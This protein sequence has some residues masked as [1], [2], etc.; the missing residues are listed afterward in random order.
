MPIELTLEQIEAIVEEFG[1]CALRAK[2]CGFDGVEIHGAHG[3]LIAEF[4]SLYS[5]KRTD[6]YGGS[7]MNRLRFPVEIIKNIRQK[8][9]DDFIIDFR[10]SA[11]EM[12]EGGRTIE[13]TKAI[14]PVLQEAGIGFL[15]HVSAGTY[16]TADAIVHPYTPHPPPPTAGL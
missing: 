5:N 13:D 4:M 6:R 15:N 3:Y 14:V 2:K 11:D 9:G 8:C 12:V 1:D 16:A 10:I 7:L